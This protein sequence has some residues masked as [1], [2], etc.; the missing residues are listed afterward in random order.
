MIRLPLQ[1]TFLLE[2]NRSRILFLTESSLLIKGA[3]LSGVVA[4]FLLTYF[5]GNSP[6]AATP[7]KVG[8]IIYCLLGFLTMGNRTRITFDLDQN[9]ITVDRSFYFLKKISHFS[10]RTCTAAEITGVNKNFR[11]ILQFQDSPPLILGK[12]ASH[13]EAELWQSAITDMLPLEKK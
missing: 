3:L 5:G 8:V 7:L 4:F 11:T 9:R 6:I 2:R 12:T 1:K 13:K 10:T